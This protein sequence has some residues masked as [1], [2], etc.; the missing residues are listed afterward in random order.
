MAKVLVIDKA[1]HLAGIIIHGRENQ[2]QI[3]VDPGLRL[4]QVFNIRNETILVHLW[5]VKCHLHDFFHEPFSI[6]LI[7]VGKGFGDDF[8]GRADNEYTTFM[9][10]EQFDGLKH[11]DYA[12]FSGSGPGRL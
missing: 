7:D 2:G 10:H 9:V 4:F 11:L 5:Q 1:L 8:L 3:L 6:I 12:V